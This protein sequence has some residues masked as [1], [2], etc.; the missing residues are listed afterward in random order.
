MWAGGAARAR[1]TAAVQAP[2]AA[3]YLHQSRRSRGH[4]DR[5]STRRAFN[6]PAGGGQPGRSYAQSHGQG[7]YLAQETSKM[8]PA[9]TLCSSHSHHY[10]ATDACDRDLMPWSNGVRFTSVEAQ[11][12]YLL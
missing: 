6:Q 10:V 12:V 2:P 4:G 11:T 1:Q 7:D 8:Q 9:M 5:P 3:R